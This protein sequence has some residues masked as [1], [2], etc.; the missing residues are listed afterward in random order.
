MSGQFEGAIHRAGWGVALQSLSALNN[1]DGIMF[2]AFV[3][4]NFCWK[5]KRAI[6]RAARRIPYVE[7][8]A[9]IVHF[10]QEIPEWV[11]PSGT[12]ADL[13]GRDDWQSSASNCKGL[14]ALSRYHGDWIERNT[15]IPCKALLHPTVR[16]GTPFS[17]D[18][19]RANPR[20]R[21]LQIGWW[22][23]KIDS[24]FRLET[25]SLAKTMLWTNTAGSLLYAQ[26]HRKHLGDF[27]N[28]SVEVID[29]LSNADYDSVLSKNVVF[30]DVYDASANN[31][32]LDCIMR[33]TPLVT[34]RHPA[35]E[36]YLGENYPLFFSRLDEVPSLLES[37]DLLEAGHRHL[38]AMDKT[39][40]APER[41]LQDLVT[42]S[43]FRSN[44]EFLSAQR[45]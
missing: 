37:T 3:E 25:T 35:I 27:T 16:T 7:P 13:L 41:F 30:L 20:K 34:N 5:W 4:S 29:Y 18:A 21:V 36:E 23:R 28:D 32:V 8:W 17:L 10:P 11:Y 43:V 31:I 40:F 33:D 44:R 19:F 26:R 14:Y 6:N 45:I 9:G 24:I 22:L 15:G 42:S 1:P 2:D 38:V 39:Q 12:W